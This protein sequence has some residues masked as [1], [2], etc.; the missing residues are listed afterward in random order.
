MHSSKQSYLITVADNSI[1][2]NHIGVSELGHDSCL[3][4]ELD[5]VALA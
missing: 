5:L 1:E 3:L 2:L 4:E